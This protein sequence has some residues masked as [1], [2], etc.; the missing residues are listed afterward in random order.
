LTLSAS[1]GTY[2][3][4]ASSD[5]IQWSRLATFTMTGASQ[6]YTDGNAGSAPHRFYQLVIPH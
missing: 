2:D 5:L 6:Q 4:Q 3:L 1:Q